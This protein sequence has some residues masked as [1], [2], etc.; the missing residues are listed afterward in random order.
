MAIIIDVVVNI[1]YNN[2]LLLLSL[3]LV[4]LLTFISK[5]LFSFTLYK[6]NEI[7]QQ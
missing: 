7:Q 1:K 3:L 2:K 4:I 5:T 6:H